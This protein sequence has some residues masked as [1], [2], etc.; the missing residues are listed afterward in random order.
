[1]KYFIIDFDSTL[2]QAET[3][4]EIAAVALQDNPHKE[5]ILRKVKD[6]TALGMEGKLKFD[7]SLKKR[8]ELLAFDK[9]IVEKVAKNLEKKISPSFLRNKAFFKEYKKQ[10]YVVSGGFR[11]MIMP[12]ARKF[13]LSDSQVLANDFRYDKTGR[14]TGVD[15]KNPL[16][17]SGGKAKAVA[18]LGLKGELFVIGDGMTDWEIKD[19]LKGEGARGKDIKFI[20]FTENVYR[21]AV[22]GKADYS[23]P[24]LDEFLYQFKLPAAISY[25]KTRMSVL[26]L[27]NVHQKAVAAFEKEGYAVEYYEKAIAQE[28]LFE[29]IS[30]VSILGIRSRT[31]VT[32]AVLQKAKKLMAIGAFCIGTDQIDLSE[33]LARGIAV[34]N[35]P[36]SNTRSVVELVLGEI[37]MLARGVF[38]K[39]NKLHAGVWDKS[40]TGSVEIRGKTLGIIGYGNIGSQISVLAEALG[41]NVVFYDIVEKLALG[42]AKQYSSLAEV[43]ERADIITI[44]VDGRKENKNLISEKEF[45]QMKQGVLF[46]N[47]SRGSIVDISALMKSLKSGKVRGAALDVFPKEPEGK[48]EPFVSE[49]RGLPQVILTPHVGGS[50][51]EAQENIGVFV[52]QKIIEYVNTG[53]T[54]LSVTLPTIQLPLLQKSHRLLHIHK[55]TP[56][57]LARINTILSENHR[58]ITGQYLKTNEEIGYVITDVDKK[59][60]ERLLTQLKQIEG[61]VKFRILY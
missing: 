14:V 7:E 16:S 50:T 54:Y 47:L 4:D 35:A 37:I 44:H 11:E 36:Y 32:N 22:V 12:I 55:N 49:L 52:S 10:I 56:G 24:N 34:F 51:K 57:I 21:E 23:V 59:Y 6:I 45:A 41:M 30:D 8:L 38:E 19:R 61:T 9:K 15:V 5:D 1:M 2:I 25:P 33:A 40:A 20:A 48:D 53:S 29:K 3:L 13:G 58:N 43:C 17:Q 46:L 28:V 31:H 27:E 60:D 42:T 26:L 39:S 18:N